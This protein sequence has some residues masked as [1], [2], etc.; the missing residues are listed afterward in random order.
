MGQ[1]GLLQASD[2]VIVVVLLLCAWTD[3]RAR[4]I[5]NTLIV[6]AAVA[7][8]LSRLAAVGPGGLWPPLAAGLLSFACLFPLWRLRLLGGGDLKLFVVLSIWAGLS[9]LPELALAVALAGGLLALTFLASFWVRQRLL[10]LL[11]GMPFACA[12]VPHAALTESSETG[13]S[14][15]YGVAIA[16]GGLWLRFFANTV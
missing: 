1:L 7:A 15:P 4:R 12:L 14:L 9:R 11:S 10:P 6:L 16:A 5:P 8:V 2:A 3:L 13:R